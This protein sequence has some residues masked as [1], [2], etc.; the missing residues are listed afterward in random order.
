[1][2]KDQS[3]FI[4]QLLRD[5]KNMHM[6]SLRVHHNTFSA[7]AAILRQGYYMSEIICRC[8]AVIL[9]SYSQ[10]RESLD[11]AVTSIYLIGDTSTFLSLICGPICYTVNTTTIYEN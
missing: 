2:V 4:A 5:N 1:M 6:M 7:K 9:H 3:G 8:R 10:S 11:V